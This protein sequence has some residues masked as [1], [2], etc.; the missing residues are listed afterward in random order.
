MHK[1]IGAAMCSMWLAACGGDDG[2][3][4]SVEI[5]ELGMRI[6]EVGCAKQFE[7]CTDEEIAAENEDGF[8]SYDTEEECVTTIGGFFGALV[9][10]SLRESI[11]AGRM[12]YDAEAMGACLD[13][14]AGVSCADY[15]QSSD[16]LLGACESPFT[17]KVDAGGECATDFECKTGY[18]KGA[19]PFD[20]TLGECAEL[21]GEG[22]ECP[23]FE[24]AD[25]LRCDMGH[26]A[27]EPPADLVGTCGPRLENGEECFTGDDCVSGTCDDSAETAVCA[28]A[29][30]TCD[31][32]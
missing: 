28:D 18:C 21:P 23:D 10:S 30:P 22:D 17:P 20:D 4:G 9:T 25:G 16:D 26:E 8:G 7:C 32:R 5:E 19:N 27:A 14:A 11:E 31:G 15:D 12:A 1:G 6:A 2:G 13:E 3:G 29:A 24:C